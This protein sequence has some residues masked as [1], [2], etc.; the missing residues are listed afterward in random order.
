MIKTYPSLFK[1]DLVSCV[2]S[3]NPGQPVSAQYYSTGFH[4]SPGESL[5]TA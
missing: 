2:I 4:C 3:K 1:K 5:D